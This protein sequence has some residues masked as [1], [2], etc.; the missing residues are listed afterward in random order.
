MKTMNG[1]TLVEML[2]VVAAIGIMAAVAIPN[3]N[4]YTT[5]SKIQEGTSQ[6]ADARV[7]LEQFFQDNRSYTAAALT[8]GCPTAASLASSTTY[9]NYTCVNTATTYTVTATGK[10]SMLGYTYTINQANARTSTIPTDW[11]PPGLTNPVNCW[12]VKKRSA[13]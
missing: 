2:V 5:R 7:K 1:F 12:V 4:D 8:G 10:T 6:L 11:L 13:C 3:Y 9:F